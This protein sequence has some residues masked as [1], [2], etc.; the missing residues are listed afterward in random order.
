MAVT[1][2]SDPSK[3]PEPTEPGTCVVVTYLDGSTVACQLV[4]GPGG[5]DP[6]WYAAPAIDDDGYGWADFLT[7]QAAQLVVVTPG[8]PSRG[9]GA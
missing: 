6:L 3:C 5:D 4:A 8:L 1:I 7:D 2:Y 9:D